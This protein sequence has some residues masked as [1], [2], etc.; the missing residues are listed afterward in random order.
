MPVGANAGIAGMTVN[1]GVNLQEFNAGMTQVE[2]RG[3][4]AAQSLN[5]VGSALTTGAGI[6]A[7]FAVATAALSAV[8]GAATA[9]G[10]AIVGLNSQL[11]QARIG[12]TAMTGSAEKANAFVKQLQDFAAK[13]TFE[14]P[15][16]LQASRQLMG[17]GVQAE[18]VI[19]ILKDVSTA[20][21][22][23]GGGDTAITAV[24]RALTQMMATGKVMAGDMNQL[25]QA[26]LP[27]W[28]MLADSMGMTIGQV[29][30]LSE[31]GK[32]SADQMLAAF[33]KFAT[34]NGMEQL[35][36][37]SSQT[38]Q[39]ATSNII[40]GLRN[41]GAEGFQPLFEVMRDFAVQLAN[42]L[43]SP[44]AKNFGADLKA[45]VQDV[46]DSARPLGEALQRAFD[47]FKTDGIKGALS[48]ILNDVLALGQQMGGAGFTLVQEFAN[49]IIQGA[50]SAVTE[51]ANFVAE[52]IASFLIGNSPPPTGPLSAIAQGGTNVILAYVDGMRQGAS[53]V[54]DVAQSI[55][56]AF[57]N[58]EGAM[59]L[60]QGRAALQAAG[61]D[62]RALQEAVN[63]AEGVLRGLDS[64]I[65]DNQSALRD[66]QNAATD[67]K[68]A[69]E[70]AI[71]PLQRQVDALREANDLTQKQADLQSRIQ[72]A[73]LKGQLAAAQGDPV[74]RAQ[75][76][77]QLDALEQQ[78]KELSLQ[79]RSLGIQK[80]R[81]QLD[82][83]AR[84]EKFTDTSFAA[85]QNALATRRLN[86]QQQQNQIQ[87]QLNGMVDK[88]AVARI[89][90]QQATV[91]ATKDQRDINQ[92]VQN[93][94][95]ELEAA[96]LLAQIKDLK[97]QQ[98]ALLQPINERI[99][100]TRREGQ[101]LQE[102]RQHWQDIKS[103]ITDVMQEQRAQAAQAKA[104][105]KE[106][107]DAAKKEALNRP[108][109]LAGIFTPEAITD[110]GT[111]VGESFLNGV[112][113]YLN[114]NAQNLIAGAVG[115]A[116]GG[117]AFGPLGAV[118]GAAF[119]TQLVTA[120]QQ[121]VPDISTILGDAF[122]TA[123]QAIAGDWS[124]P[125]PSVWI[126][127]FVAKIGQAFSELGN[128]I[129][130]A[131]GGDIQGA[132]ITALGDAGAL[133]SQIF[134][135]LVSAVQQID[136]AAVWNVAST[137]AE[138]MAAWFV[139][140][141]TRFTGWLSEQVAQIDWAAVWATTTTVVEAMATWFVDVG[142]RFTEWM[143][144][145][146]A[147]IDWASIWGSI[148][149]AATELTNAI[150]TWAASVDWPAVWESTG[151]SVR[152]GMASLSSTLVSAVDSIDGQAF[153]DAL[154]RGLA[155]G[156]A[157]AV[158]L[159]TEAIVGAFQGGLLELPNK[160][161]TVFRNVV[162]GFVTGLIDMFRPSVTALGTTVGGMFQS[163]ASGIL[164][165]LQTGIQQSAPGLI[166]TVMT[167]VSNLLINTFKT[168]LG[169]AS[170]S[171]VFQ[172]F[173]T[174]IVEGLTAGITSTA[175]TAVTALTTML[176][177]MLTATNTGMTAIN[178]EFTTQLAAILVLITENGV[179][180]VAA[181][182][183]Y[184]AAMLVETTTG[185]TA[186]HTGM[187]TQL[188]EILALIV[189][190]GATYV[191]AV[192][193]YMQAWLEASTAG[194]SAIHAG[195]TA[196][197]QEIH[198]AVMTAGTAIV[199]AWRLTMDQSLTVVTS[200]TE[201][202]R[203]A[204]TALGAAMAEGI[205]SSMQS[206]MA[207]TGVAGAGLQTMSYGGTGTG[208]GPTV[209]LAKVDTSSREA[210]LRSWAAALVD[211]E[212]RTGIPASVLWGLINAENG[213][214]TVGQLSRDQNNYF[215]MTHVPGNKYQAGVDP[216]GGRFARYATP[217]DSL[218]DFLYQMQTPHYAAA[219]QNRQDPS[220]FIDELIRAGYIVDE[221]GYPVGPWKP[222]IMEGANKF[223]QTLPNLNI[224]K[225]IGAGPSGGIDVRRMNLGVNQIA[226]S[227]QAGLSNA[228]A[229]AI[230]GPYAAVLFAQATGRNPSL[231]EAR[232][233]AAQVGWKP[234][235]PNGAGGMGGTGNFMSLLG[236]MGIQ[237]VRQ[238]GTPENINSALSAGRP[239]AISTPNHYF[240]ARGGTAQGGMDVGATGTVMSGGKATMTLAEVQAIGGGINDIIV[241]TGTMQRDVTTAFNNFQDGTRQMGGAVQDTAGQM[242]M[243]V[244]TV[245]AQG[246]TSVHEVQVA[247]DTLAA[248][249]ANG[250]VPAG[251]AAA[252]A[253]GQM[254]IGVQPLIATWAAGAMT[255]DQLGTSIVQLAASSG[256]ATQPLAALQA[257]N[258][259]VG[260]ALRQVLS[261]LAATN[262]AFAQIEQS[263]A[264]AQLT[265]EQLADVL[266]RGL[267]NVTG[268]V[269]MSLGQMSQSVVPLQAAFASGS[270]SGEQFVQSVVQLGAQSGL[271]QAPLRL[272]QDGVITANQALAMVLQTAGQT[273]P[274]IAALAE[275]VGELPAPA[276]EAATAFLEWI[277]SL[278]ETQAAT[279]TATDA[280]AT[281][282]D[283]VADIQAPM[284]DASTEALQTLPT[285]T[286][287][288]LDQTVS[289]I[290][291]IV[292]PASEAARAVG[293][294]I[295]QSLREAVEA[296]AE[297]IAESARNI[298]ERALEQA[299]AAAQKVKDSA[300][301][302][303][304]KSKG[305]HDE[306]AA[307]GR[308]N[309][310]VWTLVGEEGPELISP[311]GY[312][313]NTG[314]TTDM[315]L[316]G[317]NSGL[318][319][320]HKYA[321]GGKTKS[322]S[323]KSSSKSSKKSKDSGG[324]NTAVSAADTKPKAPEATPKSAEE[325]A[326]EADI[327]GNEIARAKVLAEIA[328][329]EQQ[330]FL[331]EHELEKAL[332]GTF[333]QQQE[334]LRLKKMSLEYEQASLNIQAEIFPAQYQM[335]E[336]QFQQSEASKGDLATRLRVNDLN[337]EQLANNKR[338]AELNVQSLDARRSL[339]DVERQI[340]FAQKGSLEDQLRVVD[341]TSQQHV[342]QLQQNELQIKAAQSNEEIRDLQASI[343]RT[344][345]GTVAQRKVLADNARRTAELDVKSLE[346]Q[347]K[348]LPIQGQI[349]TV[350]AKIE[351]IQKGT[352]A[353]Q[354][355]ALDNQRVSGQL[356]LQEIG[357]QAQ[358]RAAEKGSLTDQ[359]ASIDNQTALAQLR[360]TEISVQSQ[361]RDVESGKL[362]LSQSEINA[363]HVQLETIESQRANLNDQSE[364]RQLN[365][366]I[367][368]ADAQKQMAALTMQKDA[369]SD[370]AEVRQINS[371]LNTIDAQKQL[372]ALQEQEAAHTRVQ[373]DLDLQR[374]IITTQSQLIQAQNE[375]AVKGQQ[376]KLAELQVQ[377]TAYQDQIAKLQAQ[378]DV[379][380]LQVQN[381]QLQNQI[382][383]DAFA[384]Q[385][386]LLANQVNYYNTLVTLAQQENDKISAQLALVDANNKLAAA[387]Y[388][389]Q[390]I[391][392]DAMLTRRQH[393]ID[394]L[395][396]AKKQIEIHTNLIT[397][398]NQIAASG[399]E[400]RLLALNQQKYAQ[401]ELIVGMNSQ[402]GTLNAQLE[403]Y[404]K[405]REQVDAINKNPPATPPPGGTP[406]PG[407]PPGTVAATATKEGAQTLYLSRG[408]GTDGWY[409]GTGQLVV[410]G[411]NASP[412]SGYRVKWLAEGGT[413]HKGE[414]AVVGE[415]GPELAIAPRDLH[416]FPHERSASIARA[417]SK[418]G[419][420]GGGTSDD[421]PQKNVVVNVEYHRHGGED[422]GQ[423]TIAQ[424][425]REAVNVALR[426]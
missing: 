245:S 307:G 234:L 30:K 344:L 5:S 90:A 79:E 119:M 361:L 23:V 366:T 42:A 183:E 49:G 301:D 401:D 32:I 99:E 14:F 393:D 4:K 313:Y 88:E 86:I 421:A 299:R 345:A 383:A 354:Y 224:P 33:H 195:L 29:R 170:P 166:T 311:S 155:V 116:L 268:N 225:P 60:S 246:V 389:A 351:D 64:Q 422:Y 409:T 358:I 7:G 360:L 129:R 331:Y 302:G 78:E 353:D 362:Q 128:I 387:G 406:A 263:M 122:R 59:T 16:L 176:A 188:A 253:V 51:A 174:A 37:R 231:A 95:R 249:I 392:L 25:A 105:A 115:A 157:V 350:Q 48:S 312:V 31:E 228:D 206:A 140:V 267:A 251:L 113:A 26:G 53:G 102:Q 394:M 414:V 333:D 281:V 346:V 338:I 270:V 216:V 330:I 210:S 46:V 378:N 272:M 385:Q 135:W 423:G 196:Q 336:L 248:S 244:Q 254:A 413:W 320:L 132:I 388:A 85:Q 232:Q 343:N 47:A 93:L 203:N 98:Q 286:T 50:A 323:K 43:T 193:A 370:Q 314:E 390:L 62:M 296:G 110:T 220:K 20:V 305:D 274:A 177:Q 173:G 89:K 337:N 66:Y 160:L 127:P 123:Q 161:V 295:V 6:G 327:L 415:E 136:W 209:R 329:I 71:D 239:V 63:D 369:L 396:E 355:A 55:V 259:S 240:V 19:P 318:F 3:A 304:G 112:R 215:S 371:D 285:A 144:A 265:T 382:R 411:G 292:G 131:Q 172:E 391:Q 164:T 321:K 266:L 146:V 201:Q 412:P 316:S 120:V 108:S 222:R 308:L 324:A 190:N 380:N 38:W 41:I 243:Q 255:S 349:A 65:R 256:Q 368:T 287:E 213:G 322:S 40:D 68:S 138:G 11:E 91:Q 252:G 8:S 118:A 373:Q 104:D 137:V 288:A 334:Q 233:L 230:C 182:A 200:Y 97:E 178:T 36:E 335:K 74:K 291:D 145:G 168:L 54:T 111:K 276:T 130:Q 247:S 408:A 386:V 426:S 328:P 148:Q 184:M 218:E 293:E 17:M 372:L 227:Q 294:A 377:Q 217:Q 117:A 199:G 376:E 356:R 420:D 284:Q 72:L 340:G 359:Y 204:G 223:N 419:G 325:L 84:G 238:A 154:G 347:T 264:G 150:K 44:E 9:A 417:M 35:L 404:K 410:A 152:T 12:F 407:G 289:A 399:H 153:G 57:G 189:Q 275:G 76:T 317:I 158:K 106:A 379:L 162:T 13:T 125:D 367:A 185:L 273:N 175:A 374:Q 87:Q 45:T 309:A 280:V 339:A 75:L 21:M 214:G 219:W 121:R 342:I 82:A 34:E 297:Q 52:I 277:K 400:A 101:A 363:L 69:Y 134:D 15:G 147:S 142:A 326:I 365:A 80:Q 103:A 198:A 159:L 290:N 384:T 114:A 73:Q 149:N 257:G 151:N 405:I 242:T 83:Q 364:I 310:G 126:N 194:M 211:A 133:A 212:R 402:L 283:A 67:I 315:L 352:L 269:Q 332:K 24:N 165:G 202:F 109:N 186:I 348:L 221:P 341:Y 395:G 156:V 306:K 107:A 191:E 397:T 278:Q 298:V 425:V 279:V 179:T 124:M 237:A 357:L 143:T 271:T 2:Q 22:R 207:S 56:D 180:Y 1:V 416:V 235:Q 262:P 403:V 167:T 319:T 163:A 226:A 61:Q 197:M 303:G 282:P 96:P 424:I 94:Q 258:I 236:Q 77:S 418:F 27:A 398:Q 70:A 81:A 260:E 375:L 300:G 18:L 381:I 39:A 10:S 141:G 171:T 139:D 169:I 192:T 92:E 28:K 250:V 261:S 58:V 187:T 229:Q 241:L 208:G 181:V 205:S 100:A